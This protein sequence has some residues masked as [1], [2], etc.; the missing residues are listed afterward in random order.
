V[1]SLRSALS[2]WLIEAGRQAAG[3]EVDPVLLHVR[4]QEGRP[5]LVLLDGVLE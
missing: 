5:A 2:R 1:T 4:P 3:F